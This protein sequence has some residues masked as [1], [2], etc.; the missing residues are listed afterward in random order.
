MLWKKRNMGQRRKGGR[1]A[2]GKKILYIVILSG[3][4]TI[5]FACGKSDTE[6]K[7]VLDSVKEVQDAIEKDTL[8]SEE[9]EASTETTSVEAKS[10][11]S[12]ATSSSGED[13]SAAEMTAQVEAAS[14]Q[15]TATASTQ[16]EIATQSTESSEAAT[17]IQN[18]SL[19]AEFVQAMDSYEA[20]IDEYCAFMDKYASSDGSDLTLLS[21]YATYMSK[22][23][24]M[25]RDFDAWN[26]ETMSPVEQEYYIGVQTRV[27]QKLLQAAQ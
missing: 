12:E 4:G 11:A 27:S 13:S 7:S 2:V 6:N 19:R 22:Y 26:S 23:A 25:E 18:N 9:T 16:A 10:T 17:A 1:Y 21:D 15:N 8:D 24:Q 20:F 5:S 14:E 3:I